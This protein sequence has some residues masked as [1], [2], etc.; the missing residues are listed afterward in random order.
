MDKCNQCIYS[1]TAPVGCAIS[2]Y[3]YYMI[4]KDGNCYVFQ[5]KA[6]Q[7]GPVQEEDQQGDHQELQKCRNLRRCEM[8]EDINRIHRI[9]IESIARSAKEGKMTTEIPNALAVKLAFIVEKLSPLAEEMER[10]W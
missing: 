1:V 3:A 4:G 5:A 2:E 10:E 7:E 6:V 9:L 8:H